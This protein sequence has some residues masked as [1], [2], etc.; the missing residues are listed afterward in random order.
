M[1][2]ERVIRRNL[3]DTAQRQLVDEFLDE[4]PTTQVGRA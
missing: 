4:Q 2:A 1:A 3:D